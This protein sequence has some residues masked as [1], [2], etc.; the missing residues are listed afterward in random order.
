MSRDYRLYLDDII[1]AMEKIIR[2]SA[3]LTLEDFIKDEKTVDAVIRNFTIIG[4]AA[5]N[6][7]DEIKAG[8]PGVPWKEMAG[9]RDKLVHQ[10]FGVKYDVL[11]KTIRNRLPQIKPQII[12]ILKQTSEGDMSFD[13]R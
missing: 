4:E 3:D 6:I 12:S 1:E 10:Y 2:Y 7:P 11:W 9:I 13:A 8:Q 5:K